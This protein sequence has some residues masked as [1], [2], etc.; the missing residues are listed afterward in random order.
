MNT[1]RIALIIIDMQQGMQSATLAP[2]NNPDAEHN[3]L[4]LRAA[5][6]QSG[7]AVVHVRHM[8]R[9]PLSVFFPGQPGAQFQTRFEP[10][11]DEHV[12]EKNVPDAF[13]QTG[14][15]RWLHARAI[16]QLVLVGVSTN[17]SVE[18]SARSAGNVG[19]ATVVVSDATFAF[20]LR[21]FSGTLHS[22]QKVHEMALAN[23]G[24][25]YATVRST[26]EI[27]H[28]QVQPLGFLSGQSAV[29][30]HFD[31]MGSAEIESLFD[32]KP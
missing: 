25:G 8:S 29:P 13:I 11:D 2:R 10:L 18:S 9:D 12:V 22:A 3:I 21:D 15:E 6:R 32:S 27:L 28:N 16:G 1:S 5:W 14:L 26:A 17:N 23:L 31:S 7:Q 4:R 19:F 30:D 24:N 20:D